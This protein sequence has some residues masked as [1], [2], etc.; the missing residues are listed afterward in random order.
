MINVLLVSSNEE[1]FSR[2]TSALQ[3]HRDI[4]IARAESGGSALTFIA[5][6][7]FDLVVTDETL[8]DMSG[9][10][11]A[12]KLVSQNPFANCAAISRLSSED[13]HEVSEGLGLLMQLPPQPG[14]EHAQQL[15]THYA[16]I[17]GRTLET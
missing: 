15:L 10:D 2:F 17:T 13:F 9:L 6:T 11:F 7:A 12:K 3:K 5:D 1:T 8:D 16:K 4:R 14:A